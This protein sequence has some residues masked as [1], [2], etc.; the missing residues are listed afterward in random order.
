MTSP[1]ASNYSLTRR[2]FVTLLLPM[3]VVIFLSATISI[4]V[5]STSINN[6]YDQQMRNSA[7]VLSAFLHFEVA[8][9]SGDDSDH[10]EED[11]EE[12]EDH[13]EESISDELVEIVSKIESDQNVAVYF[14]LKVDNRT[15]FTSA[16]IRKF[17]AC[18]DGFNDFEYT[19]SEGDQSKWRCFR[20]THELDQTDNTIV[21]ELFEN[22]A[23]RHEAILS[24]LQSSFL[25]LFVLPLL[26]LLVIY[27]AVRVAMSE[28]RRFSES[29]QQRSVD[30]LSRL[31]NTGKPRELLPVVQSVNELLQRLESGI[32]RE[33]RFTDDAAHELRTPVTS[34]KLLGQ[35][36]QR[37]NKDPR[38]N[39]DLLKM[40]DAINQCQ[41]LIEQLLRIARLQTRQSL[42]KEKVDLVNLVS[43][44][45]GLLAPQITAKQLSV[46]IDNPVDQLVVEADRAALVLLVNNLLS[47]ATKFNSDNKSIYIVIG[48][49]TLTIED[50]GAGI[51]EDD[52]AR[53]FDRFFRGAATHQISGSGLG[54][55]LA[56][57]IADMHGF[58][59]YLTH[60]RK[61]SGA[62][63][64][65]Q[66]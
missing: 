21:T 13:E 56:K 51:P 52:R 9:H 53:I 33:K 27:W 58:E 44:Q 60:P 34:I 3:L 4:W 40:H 57:W 22:V 37:E 29:V 49:Q 41:Y 8:E 46:Q 17:P 24:L 54:L 16:A 10:D 15:V 6:L 45:L 61:G 1:S 62:A 26:V 18:T 32:L 28:L 63:F 65:L 35:L 47:N 30:N 19:E 64:V 5:A 59:L 50:D 55:S 43:E 7:D 31:S 25:P 12:D 48:E 23:Q 11:E 38:L 20:R 36:I 2:L 14:R 66:F 39:N 42:Q